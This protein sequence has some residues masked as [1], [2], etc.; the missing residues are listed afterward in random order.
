MAL[1]TQLNCGS[2]SVVKILQIFNEV[3]GGDLGDV[4]CSNSIDLWTRRCGLAAY[5]ESACR[6]SDQDYCLIAD[7]SMMIGSSKLFL[8]L[9]TP[10]EHHGHPLCH[11]DMSVLGI[12]VAESF[13]G[14]RVCEALQR[15]AGRTGHAP[16]Y[17]ITDNASIMRKGVRLT[18]QKH[19]YDVSHS[20]GMYLERTYKNDSEFNDLSKQVAQIQFRH[21]MKPIAYILPPKQRSI[22]RFIN[23]DGWVKWCKNVLNIYHWLGKEEQ[24]ALK[25]VR[26]YASLIEELSEVMACMRHIE[27]ICKQKGLSSTTAQLCIQH[28]RDTL[29]RGNQRMRNLAQSVIAFFVREAALVD[30]G[31]VHHNSTDI[32]EST[33][34]IYKE[35]MSP[36]KLY[37]ATSM[38]LTIPA[39]QMVKSSHGGRTMDVGEHLTRAKVT[40]LEKWKLNTFQT[41]LVSKRNRV[42]KMG[43]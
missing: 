17:V 27:D 18:G 35:K 38:I 8:T 26:T 31:E 3:S 40:E 33:F 11:E 37:G 12:D 32:I 2:R 41:N 14:E 10:A 29:F 20:L 23:M 5:Q 19:H 21:N 39:L 6:F 30:K 34:G 15:A 24:E 36:N 28:V 4:P 25:C 9:A 13:N 22:S 1:R 7:E 43:A 16:S 42:L